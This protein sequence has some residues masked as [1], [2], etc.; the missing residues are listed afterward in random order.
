MLSDATKC[1]HSVITGRITS[2][3]VIVLGKIVQ[4]RVL[5][6]HPIDSTYTMQLL[7]ICGSERVLKDQTRRFQSPS[8]SYDPPLSHS[9]MPQQHHVRK[10]GGKSGPAKRQ[11]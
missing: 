7:Q 6:K 9:S 5:F 2:A 1:E 4:A 8:S 11:R 10:V 3:C